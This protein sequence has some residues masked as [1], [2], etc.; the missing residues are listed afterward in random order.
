MAQKLA[1]LFTVVLAIG[2]NQHNLI[3]KKVKN[4]S[5]Q[6]LVNNNSA[7]AMVV[8]NEILVADVRAVVDS[9]QHLE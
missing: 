7:V 4:A 6:S 2:C 3:N 9:L 5:G 8:N 1:A